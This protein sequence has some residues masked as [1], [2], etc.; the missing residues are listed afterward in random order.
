ML[1][2]IVVVF[3]GE[4]FI[5]QPFSLIFE[6]KKFGKFQGKGGEKKN[7]GRERKI[8]LGVAK[9][10]IRSKTICLSSLTRKWNGKRTWSI[11]PNCQLINWSNYQLTNQT[12]EWSKH[13]LIKWSNQ[14][15]NWSTD[16]VI[17]SS[18]DPLINWSTDQ[19]INWSS[20]QVIHW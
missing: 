6:V 16:Q 10:S 3:V 2:I 14:L 15:I 17:N 20:N 9:K 19:V 11:W 18:T 5:N 7:K 12:M 4:T 8:G 1:S 13:G